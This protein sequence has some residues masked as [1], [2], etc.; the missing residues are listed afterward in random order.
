MPSPFPGMDPYLEAPEIWPD[1]HANLIIEIQASLNPNLR[2]H[3]V[4]RVEQRIYIS[5]D[6]DPGRVAL[7]PDVRVDQTDKRRRNDISRPPSS[8]AIQEPLILPSLLDDEIQE[9]FIAVK[10]VD[11]DKLVTVIEVLSPTNKIHGSRGRKSFLDKRQEMLGSSIHWVEIDLLRGGVPSARF[12]AMTRTDYRFIVSR[13]DERGKTKCWPFGVRQPFPIVGIPL[14]EP[15]PDVPLDLG[16]VF[17]AVYARAAY[18]LSIDYRKEPSPPLK[19]AD[20]KWAKDL[21]KRHR[22]R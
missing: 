2:P 7:V 1:V 19:G 11:T 14:R 17:E 6:D 10:H 21:L 16:M 8:L 15:D 13:A 3:Y 22:A 12:S 9:P 20:G 5:D 4:A 18:D